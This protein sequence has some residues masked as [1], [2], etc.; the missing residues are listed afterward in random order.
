MP[1]EVM[2]GFCETCPKRTYSRCEDCHVYACVGCQSVHVCVG[3]PFGEEKC[4]GCSGDSKHHTCAPPIQ[5]KNTEGSEATGADFVAAVWP[6]RRGCWLPAGHREECPSA[7]PSL[8]RDAFG[9]IG[10]QKT[11]FCPV[12]E[13]GEGRHT[14]GRWPGDG[15]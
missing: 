11:Q 2:G 7:A 10:P 12:C 8:D 6:H 3:H 9:P 13:F 15:R 4:Y 1:F 5:L 14:C